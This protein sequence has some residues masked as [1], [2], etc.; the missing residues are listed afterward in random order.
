Y[1]VLPPAT[2]IEAYGS[3]SLVQAGDNYF[4]YPA[5][6]SS[7]PELKY[8]NGTTP[9]VAGQT[10]NWVPIGAEQTASGYEVVW[11]LA[12]ADQYTVWNTDA[13]GTNLSSPIGI[14][15][16]SSAALEALEASFRQD[17]NGDGVIG[18]LIEAYG[19]TRLVQIADNYFL[20]PTA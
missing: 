20:Y 13:N 19:S 8:M 1:T 15:S 3:T 7:G 18:T 5:G 17:L 11:K 14:V 4:L 12:G 6:G 9:V 2:V 16:G 10:G